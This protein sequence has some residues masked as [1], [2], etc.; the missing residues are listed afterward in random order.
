VLVKVGRQIFDQFEIDEDD[1]PARAQ[2]TRKTD[3]QPDRASSSRMDRMAAI[4]RILTSKKTRMT[5]SVLA[6]RRSPTKALDLLLWRT[7]L[8][9]RKR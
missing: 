8:T 4:Y 1:T 3:V 9:Q 5:V 7:A 6:H 2:Q